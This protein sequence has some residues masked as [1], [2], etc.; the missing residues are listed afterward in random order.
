MKREKKKERMAIY[1]CFA[2]IRKREGSF[3]L[4]SATMTVDFLQPDGRKPENSEEIEGEERSKRGRVKSGLGDQ[5][6]IVNENG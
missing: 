5:E 3:Y 1:F 4:D 6:G 2:G